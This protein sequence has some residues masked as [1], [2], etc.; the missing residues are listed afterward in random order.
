M[1]IDDDYPLA[2]DNL[3]VMYSLGRIYLYDSIYKDI[4]KPSFSERI[5]LAT[6]IV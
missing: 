1:K 5:I 2:V 4:C 6:N 3:A